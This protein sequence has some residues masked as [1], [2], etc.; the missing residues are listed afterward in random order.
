M[1]REDLIGQKFNYLLVSESKGRDKH[2]HR[3]WLCLC[4]CGNKVILSTGTIKSGHTKSCGCFYSRE[5]LTG[6]QFSYLLV[7]KDIG[8]HM[9]LCECKCG[10]ETTVYTYHLKRGL[11]KSCGCY[12]K[13]RMSGKNAPNYRHD[14]TKE[15]R[16]ENKNRNYN[17]KNRKWKKKVYERDNYTCQVCHR[18]GGAIEAHHIYSWH[19]HKKL[20]FV[21]SNG[22]TLCKNCHKEFH[23][24]YTRKN[25]TRKQLNQF[26][27]GYKNDN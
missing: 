25:N 26:K 24:I 12:F 5:N 18:R 11:I 6:K 21:T 1:K 23:K 8:N 27:M 9:W 19:S 4:D 15:E 3:L 7:K 22:I 2:G 14:L 13:E 17:P 20:R 10:K 16:E